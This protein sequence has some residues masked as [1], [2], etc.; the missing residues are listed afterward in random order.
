MPP[1]GAVRIEE[2][3]NYFDYEYPQPAKE[4][5]FSVNTEISDALES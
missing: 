5:P 4:D 2:M 1:A 3:I